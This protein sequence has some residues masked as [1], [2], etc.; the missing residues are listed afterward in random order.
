M[1]SVRIILL[2]IASAIVY[3]IVH[4][5]VTARV[6][7]EYFTIGH[8][9]IFDTADPTL[10]AFGW[11]IL[12]TWWVGLFL[13]IPLAVVARAGRSPKRSMRYLI[14]PIVILMAVSALFAFAAS[15]AGFFLA[16]NG[17]ISLGEPLASR[18]PTQKHMAFLVDLWAHLA[19]YIAASVGGVYIIVRIAWSRFFS[20]RN[21]PQLGVQSNG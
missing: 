21:S 1:E 9:P 8:P 17:S 6:C 11:G 19:S 14:G 4:D 12:A 7:V 18:V 10:L 15:T 2:C 16:N 13:G 20:A 5:Q 3:G